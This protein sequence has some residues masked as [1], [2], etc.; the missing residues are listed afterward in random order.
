MEYRRRLRSR[1]ILSF[2]L[3]GTGLTVLFAGTTLVMRELLE[4][5]LIESTLRREVDN[6]VD[7]K[8]DNPDPEAPFFFSNRIEADI[9]GRSKFAN[10]PFDRRKFD[11][12][13]YDVVETDESGEPRHYK[14]AVRKTYDL[15]GF[16]EYDVTAQRR[17]RALLTYGLVVVV[18]VFALL[19][20]VVAV[21][22][23]TRVL[24]PVT[25]LVGRVSAFDRGRRPGPLAPHFIDDEVGQLARALDDYARRLTELVERDREFNA[26]VSH[27]LRTPLAVVR[28]AT[29]LLLAQEGLP[30]KTR[31]RI[32][33][34]ERAARQSGEL[35]QALLYLSR[36]ERQA[37]ADGESKDVAHIV[38]HV[39]D[40]HRPQLG[41]KP[42]EVVIER[43]AELEVAAPSAVLSVA[44]GNLIGNAFK[45]TQEGRV[46]VRVQ[47]Q[48]VVVEDTG[49][50]IKF[51][52]SDLVF[53]RGYRGEKATGKGA[54]LGLSI[55]RRLCDLYGWRVSLAPRPDGG[56]VATLD[57]RGV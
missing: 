50:G 41:G 10:V 30:D 25:D 54:G 15:W 1:I 32:K 5:E 17:T 19:S 2:L 33:R 6:F 12:G 36:G 9:Y 35:T 38:E 43:E 39:I 53:E 3:F 42:I 45:Y 34:I 49:P 8:R 18:I 23:S 40:T 26:D 7:F 11:T 27:E 57:F 31:E 13:V 22:L 14:L 21:W 55:V 29:E 16:L 47:D 46:T 28:G 52:E 37:P 4:E 51:E 56:A 48:R 24:R 20:L 44:L